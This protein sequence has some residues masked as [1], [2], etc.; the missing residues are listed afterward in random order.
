MHAKEIQELLK[1]LENT[2]VTEL[3]MQEGDNRIKIVRGALAGMNANLGTPLIVS[4][5]TPRPAGNP[6]EAAPVTK[7]EEKGMVL[8][9][10]FV[11]TFYRS[12]S[13]SAPPYVEIG[14]NVTKGQIICIIEA[15][16][17]MNEIEC[18]YNGRISQI[19]VETGQPVEYGDK[20]F[21]IEPV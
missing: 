18:E 12:P 2:D 8:N 4:H 6:T 19:F 15:M 1:L 11:G 17:L 13:P 9:S 3:E 14:S 5:A 20:L 21:L 7:V 16:K 10:P